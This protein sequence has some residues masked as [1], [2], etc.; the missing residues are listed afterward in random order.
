[1]SDPKKSKLKRLLPPIIITVI[2]LA[3]TIYNGIR[4]YKILA[5]NKLLGT[6]SILGFIVVLCVLAAMIYVLIQRVKEIKG[7]EED[8]FDKY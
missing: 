5:D 4:I 6:T 2:L 8:D 3:V 7:G 1:M